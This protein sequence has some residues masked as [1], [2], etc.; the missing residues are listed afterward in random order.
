M[1]PKYQ[2]GIKSCAT[3]KQWEYKV[4]VPV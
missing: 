1:R 3:Q 4:G 2:I